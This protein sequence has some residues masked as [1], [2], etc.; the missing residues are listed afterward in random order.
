MVSFGSREANKVKNAA[1]TCQ[2]NIENKTNWFQVN[3]HGGSN[4]RAKFIDAVGVENF[5]IGG[6]KFSDSNTVFSNLEF[7]INHTSRRVN[8]ANISLFQVVH[9]RLS[10]LDYLRVD[11]EV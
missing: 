10:A 6:I 3:L 5:L 11:E 2:G 8:G 9:L 1:F 4:R 7:N